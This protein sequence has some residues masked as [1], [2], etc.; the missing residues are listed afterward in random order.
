[1]GRIDRESHLPNWVY[2][3]RRCERR[4]SANVSTIPMSLLW[5]C[6][7]ALAKPAIL[8]SSLVARALSTE[9]ASPTPTATKEPS[10]IAPVPQKDVLSADVISGAP[11]M[12]IP[13][14]ERNRVL[15]HTQTFS[16]APAPRRAHIPAC[17]QHHAK[18]WGERKTLAS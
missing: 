7:N 4:L 2:G 5:A 11:G 3:C 12:I 1:V 8:R 9:V 18:R 6:S 15:H 10:E 13:P 14:A 17:P 16:R